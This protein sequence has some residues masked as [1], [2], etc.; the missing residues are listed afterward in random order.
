MS[1]SDPAGAHTLYFGPFRLD[2]QRQLLWSGATQ[3]DLRPKTWELLLHLLGRPG[4]LVSVNEL[5]DAL[6]PAQD[7]TPKALTNRIVELRRALGDDVAQPQVLQTLHRRGYRMI[8]PV[9]STPP[10]PAQVVALNRPASIARELPQRGFVGRDDELLRLELHA[11]AALSGRRQL[12]LLAGEAGMGKS[13]LIDAFLATQTPHG[14]LLGRS[15]CLEQSSEREAFGPWLSM[16]ADLAAG[17]GSAQVL[18]LLRRCAPSWLVQLPWLL[19]DGEAQQLRLSLQGAGVGRMLREACALFETL[20]QLTPLVLVLEDLHWSDA[21]SNDLLAYL[22]Q[23]RGQARLLVLCSARFAEAALN[24]H[25]LDSMSRRLLA[26]GLATELSLQSLS[27]EQVAACLRQRF[28]SGLATCEPL[29]QRLQ[30]QA[31]GHPLYLAATLDH[32]VERGLLVTGPDGWRLSVDPGQLRLGLPDALRKTI[33]ARL[34][35]LQGDALELLQAASVIGMQLPLPLLQAVLDWPEDVLHDA[36]EALVSGPNFLRPMAPQAWPS[37]GSVAAYRFGHDAYRRVL[38]EGLDPSLRQALHRRVAAALEAAWHGR[39]KEVASALAA[40]YERSAQPAS[41]ARMLEMAAGVAAQR[42]AY[43][44]ASASIEAALRQLALMPHDEARD[45]HEQRLQLTVANLRS[46]TTGHASP[47]QFAAYRRAYELAAALG[48]PREELRGCMGMCITSIVG[49]QPDEALRWT[50]HLLALAEAKQ[51]TL[52]AAAHCY[53]GLAELVSGSIPRAL[54]HFESSLSLAAEPGVPAWVDVHALS[55]TQRAWALALSGRTKDALA[56]AEA[57]LARCR[58]ICTPLD[59]AQNLYWL[60]MTMQVLG[61]L[62]R[63][64]SMFE[65]VQLLAE[66]QDAQ[67][68]RYLARVALQAAKPPAQRDAQLEHSVAE[69]RKLGEDCYSLQAHLVLAETHLLRGD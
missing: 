22:A 30:Q 20:S 4:Q 67:L 24:G 10:A 60:G 65:E 68:Y 61:D 44:E 8:C 35:L 26:Q 40:A 33:E 56:Q 42:C 55:G 17:P 21:A 69:H 23:G 18:M 1:L 41:A 6:W 37:P 29:L 58:D 13:A 66:E 12:V 27:L 47:A 57:S 32:L 48:V 54:A 5:L 59:Q 11:Q 16:L 28:G 53:A 62:R 2:R 52:R 64:G 7:V 45:R 39:L 15:V 34:S 25:P 14:S 31:E 38:Y 19:D 49:G 63:A 9:S 36:C 46:I 3:V 50:T 43:R 51:P